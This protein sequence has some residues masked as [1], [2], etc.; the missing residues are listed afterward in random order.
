MK[1]HFRT[2]GIFLK[3]TPH[4]EADYFFT[5]Y[6]KKYGL[7]SALGKSIRKINSKLRGGAQLFYF[8]EIEFIEGKNY[9]ILID[10]SSLNRFENILENVNRLGVAHRISEVITNFIKGEEKDEALWNL[11]LQ[12]FKGLN[13]K[14]IDSKILFFFFLWNFLSLLGYKPQLKNCIKCRNKLEPEKLSFNYQ[15]GGVVCKDCSGKIKNEVKINPN[16]VKIIR[17]FLSHNLEILSHVSIPK[18]KLD[19]LE[20]LSKKYYLYILEST[21]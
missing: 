1:E 14:K 18:D 5:I 11:I 13:N 6:T 10:S 8:S 17:L 15:E 21:R 4:R 16:I 12:S 7:I 2:Q 19:D 9:K 3:E 20:E